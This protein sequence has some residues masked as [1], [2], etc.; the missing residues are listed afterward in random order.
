L[1]GFALETNDEIAHAT[2]KLERKNLDLIVLNSLRDEGAGFGSDTNKITLIWR[3]NKTQY[4]GLKPKSHVAGDI[5][6][7]MVELMK[8]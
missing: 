8:S 2:Q 5:A 6:D 3:N 7:A 4:F 1:V